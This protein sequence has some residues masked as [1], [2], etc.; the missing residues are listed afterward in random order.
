MQARD[1]ETVVEYGLC[2]GCGLCESMA[3]SERVSMT[4]SSFSQLRPKVHEPLDHATLDRILTA[5]PGINLRGPDPEVAGAKGKMHTIWGPYASLARGYS[6]DPAIRFKAAAGGMMTALGV[7]LVETG[8]VDCVVHVQASEDRPM[9]TAGKISTA[10]DQVIAGAQSRYGPAAPLTEVMRLLDEGKRFAVAAKP[11][12]IAAMRNLARLDPRVDQQVPYMLTIFCGGVPTHE[13]AEKIAGYFGKEEK[14]LE[15]F[16]FRGEGWPGATHVHTKSGE[17]FELTYDQAWL[18]GGDYPWTYDVQFRC[19]ICPDAI[20]VLADVALP[21]CWIMVDGKP[22]HE[23]DDGWNVIV[24]RTVKGAALI[25]DAVAAGYVS[26]EPYEVAEFDIQHQEH[27]WRKQAALAR[28]LGM[29][30]KGQPRPTY[31]N[32]RLLRCA[33]SGGLGWSWRNFTG[34]L[35]RVR[36]GKNREPAV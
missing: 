24:A 12:D 11:C 15:I 3:G 17:T 23:E 16:R 9:H 1:L 14:D 28:G 10:R 36:Q 34:M 33:I 18:R 8:K 22:I 31:E 2:L 7:Y 21:D 27:A 13:T 20:G 25:D 4:M 35:R 5:C 6:S 30:L 26:R 19:K 32:L 29:A